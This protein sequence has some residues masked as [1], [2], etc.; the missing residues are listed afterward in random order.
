MDK[1]F[2]D[3]VGVFGGSYF[4]GNHELVRLVYTGA[5]MNSMPDFFQNGFRQIPVMPQLFGFEFLDQLIAG[6]LKHLIAVDHRWL[7]EV[8]IFGGVDNYQCFGRQVFTTSL[9][10]VN[11]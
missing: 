11:L 7:G 4:R 10:L 1:D 5:A 6:Q 2:A 8:G 9:H 3:L